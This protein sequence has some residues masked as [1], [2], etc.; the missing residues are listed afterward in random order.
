MNSSNS[1]ANIVDDWEWEEL[2]AA[3][4]R[5]YTPG[6][7]IGV[8][9]NAKMYPLFPLELNRTMPPKL[10]EDRFM[11]ESLTL[12]IPPFHFLSDLFDRKLQQ[13]IEGGLIEYNSHE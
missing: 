4:D 2:V 8:F 1:R 10:L 7:K 9:Y 12:L 5:L 6:T 3:Y 11:L 13:Y